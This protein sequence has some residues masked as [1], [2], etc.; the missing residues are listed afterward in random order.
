MF[1]AWVWSPETLPML[2]GHYE[3]GDQLPL[4]FSIG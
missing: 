4:N 1:E 3:T 2:S